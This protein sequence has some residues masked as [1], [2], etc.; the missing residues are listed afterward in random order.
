MP[1]VSHPVT[2][3]AAT[4]SSRRA[5][6]ARGAPSILDRPAAGG[7]RRALGGGGWEARAELARG[8]GPFGGAGIGGAG[9]GRGD[10]GAGPGRLRELRRSRPRGR[11]TTF[12]GGV[13]ST[14]GLISSLDRHSDLER[15]SSTKRV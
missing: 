15:V 14:E 6:G 7:G 10:G 11:E 9:R 4:M 1:V 13:K 2:G 8:A 3:R 12:G 5:S